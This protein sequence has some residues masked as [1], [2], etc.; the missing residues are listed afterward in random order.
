MSVI[1]RNARSMT[2][3][4]EPKVST[5]AVTSPELALEQR[6][7][8]RAPLAF[9]RFGERH[10]WLLGLIAFVVGGG[11]VSFFTMTTYANWAYQSIDLKVALYQ[12]V[13]GGVGGGVVAMILA[14][15]YARTIRATLE[16]PSR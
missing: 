11:A 5:S 2:G 14:F 8:F 16:R 9:A 3:L 13:A 6:V 15:A 1:D 10:P 7:L 4:D 12:V